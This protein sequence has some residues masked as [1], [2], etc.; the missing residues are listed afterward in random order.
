MQ[1]MKD[2][3]KTKMNNI[4]QLCCLIYKLLRLFVDFPSA[5]VG[6]FYR[7]VT[8]T[9]AHHGSAHYNSILNANLQDPVVTR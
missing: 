2:N 6:I 7:V 5:N 9:K 3:T 1:S 8:E 4:A